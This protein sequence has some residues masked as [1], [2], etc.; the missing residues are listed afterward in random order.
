M[1]TPQELEAKFW[2]GLNSDR[3][4]ML[5][6]DGVNDGHAQPM[7]AITYGADGKDADHGPIWFFTSKDNGLI[8]ALAQ[9]NRAM[10][11]FTS[12]G[13]DLFATIHGNLAIEQDRSM[14]EKLWNPWVAAWFEGG[15][16]DPKIELLRLDAESAEIWEN[17]NSVI[18]GV[19]MALGFGD[20]KEDY[21]D[22]VAEVSL[23]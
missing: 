5:G 21:K 15:K 20:P 7:T 17:A 13:H 9:G 19:K 3:T 22:K 1:P 23:T 4:L 18:A 6:L 12:K 11:H 16:T 10:A 8:A 2:K 14:I